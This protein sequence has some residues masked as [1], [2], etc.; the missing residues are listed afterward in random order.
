MR[1]IRRE[2]NVMVIAGKDRGKVGVVRAVI[3]GGDLIKKKGDRPR[4]TPDK[5]LVTGINLSKRHRRTQPGVAQTGIIEKE[6]PLPLSKVMLVCKS[7]NKPVRV[8]FSVRDD[9]K[10]RVCRNCGQDID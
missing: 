2:D 6:M 7:C 10:V 3:G 1:K 9:G 5:V 8:G 4:I